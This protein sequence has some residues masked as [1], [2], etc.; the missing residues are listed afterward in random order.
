LAA[1]K[2]VALILA[3]PNVGSP[4]ASETRRVV[5]KGFPF[6]LIYKPTLNGDLII[7]AIA[8][9]SRRPRYWIDRLY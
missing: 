2:T 3:F 6:W 7:F 9:H 8:H 1:E 4:C 5:I